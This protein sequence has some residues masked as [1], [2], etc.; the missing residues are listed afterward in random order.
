MATAEVINIAQ[1]VVSAPPESCMICTEDL[2]KTY[3]MG[4]EQQVQALR[5]WD[6]ER[7]RARIEKL[8]LDPKQKAGK[9]S[10]GQRAQLALT[11]AIAKRPELLHPRRAG[12]QPRPARPA[13]V[14]AAPHGGR[15]RAR[16]QR[17]P[18]LAPGGRP[19][20]RVRLPRGAG[21]L[22]R[23][24]QRRRRRAAGDALRLTGPRRDP[25]T[26]PGTQTVIEES[27]T[28]RQSTLI[29][30]TDEPSSTRAGRSS[31]SAWRTSCSRT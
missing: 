7:A 31:R 9:L 4:S 6:A 23:A 27:H 26:L 10:G 20:A 15:R 1:P 21:R 28:D 13:G 14:P 3:D 29:V 18:L 17:H 2:W 24:G 30:R 11:L 16:A 8:R 19:G 5:G 12:R 25:D 22:P